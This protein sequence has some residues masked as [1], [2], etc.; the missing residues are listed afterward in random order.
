MI[1]KVLSFILPF[2]VDV[3]AVRNLKRVLKNQNTVPQYA[4]YCLVNAPV[5]TA[6]DGIHPVEVNSIPMIKNRPNA[7]NNPT[8]VDAKP[9]FY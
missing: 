7:P 9:N 6:Y 4:A 2:I 1:I 8:F 3:A 5:M